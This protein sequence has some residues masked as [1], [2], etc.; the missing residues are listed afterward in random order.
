MT[1]AQANQPPRLTSLS[2]GGGCGCKIA[3]GLL[4]DLLRRSAPLPFFPDLLVGNDTADDA[5]VYRLNDEQA[6][7]ATTDFFMP[8]VDDPYDFGRIAAT[9]ALSDVYA[10]GGKPIMAL[11]IVGMPINVLPH[12]V[13][14]AVLKG[15]ESVCADAGI[16]LAGGHSI[17]SVEPIYG[18]V[19]LGVVDPKRVK[20]NAGGR[21]GDVLILGK[22]LGVGI[23]SAALKKDRLDAAGYAAMLG[24]TTQ[25]NRPGAELARLDGVHA[26]TDVTGFG[27]LGHTLELARGSQ[28][29]ARVR[30][31]DL[32]WLPHVASL[33][34]AGIFTGASGR[35][36]DAYGQD[37]MLPA[38]LPP[39][40][41]ALLTD[42]QTS[43]GLLVSCA[44]EAVDEVLALFHAD[45]FGEARV[46]GEMVS[47]AARVE[48][49]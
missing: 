36:W 4:A 40:A 7:V 22:P 8:I 46:I 14:A 43:G 10:M 23:L 9:N 5:A 30:Y 11:A 21:A 28:L 20:R 29:T 27:L 19:A 1:Q 38:T 32:P 31:A 13:I 37:V 6:I 15:G 2:H 3:P 16:P 25:L 48:V 35:N 12:D 44:P 42:P 24:A 39:A 33:A 17:D 49:V 47:G 45:G 34:E 41:R 18:L 26:L